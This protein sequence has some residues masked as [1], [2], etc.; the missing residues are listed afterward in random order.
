MQNDL[1][2]THSSGDQLRT[3]IN[4]NLQVGSL[5]TM[6]HRARAPR[7]QTVLA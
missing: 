7:A 6:R 4:T 5:M 1:V 3:D 2:I